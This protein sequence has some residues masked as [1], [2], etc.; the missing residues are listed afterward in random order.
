M[1]SV[2]LYGQICFMHEVMLLII[3]VIYVLCHVCCAILKVPFH[4]QDN[5]V[6]QLFHLCW[7]LC[8]A[9]VPV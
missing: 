6:D 4:A 8:R 3:C 5:A 2:V 9:L 7:A 1:F